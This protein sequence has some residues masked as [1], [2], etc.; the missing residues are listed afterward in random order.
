MLACF[1]EHWQKERSSNYGSR[2]GKRGNVCS[3]LLS[4]QL[5]LNHEDPLSRFDDLCWL[6]GFIQ[7]PAATKNFKSGWITLHINAH[8]MVFGSFVLSC[9]DGN[10]GFRDHFEEIRLQKNCI[11]M[12]TLA[13]HIAVISWPWSNNPDHVLVFFRNTKYICII[14]LKGSGAYLDCLLVLLMFANKEKWGEQQSDQKWD[15][16]RNR[17]CNGWAVESCQCKCQQR[18]Q[19]RCS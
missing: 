3:K 5:L 4:K 14:V 13:V 11:N 6:S 18:G 8:G 19:N 12:A 1:L 15:S 7:L 2:N 10:L 9:E 17:K 16:C